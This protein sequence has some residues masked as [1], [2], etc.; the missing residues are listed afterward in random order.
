MPKDLQTKLETM[1]GDYAEVTGSSFSHF[2]CPIVF[3]DEPADLCRA[4]IVNQSYLGSGD[5]WTVQ[6]ADVDNFYGGMFEGDF[7]A[8]Q[9]SGKYSPD[10]II[11]D[12]KLSRMLRPRIEVSPS[13]SRL[14]L[15]N[16]TTHNL[17]YGTQ[18]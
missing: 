15:R 13:H 14:T 5:Q 1:R 11:A 17:F 10:E 7:V 18:S 8:L 4:H 16:I 2:Y 6:R 9:H 12:P 3:R